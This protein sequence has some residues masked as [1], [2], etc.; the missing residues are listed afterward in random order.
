MFGPGSKAVKLFELEKFLSGLR[1]TQTELAEVKSLVAS[2][3]RNSEIYEHGSEMA[4][5]LCAHLIPNLFADA[6]SDVHAE[7]LMME[8]R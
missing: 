4:P 1:L 6:I 2:L 8:E 5:Y 3:L 7:L